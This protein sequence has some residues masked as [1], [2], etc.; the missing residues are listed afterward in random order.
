MDQDTVYRYRT[1]QPLSIT[2]SLQ[3]ADAVL[4]KRYS[5]LRREDGHDDFFPILMV[6]NKVEE[7]ELT[8]RG[9]TFLECPP[10]LSP[11]GYYG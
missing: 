1:V 10:E 6:Y 3:P 5:D 2:E 11:G 8:S 7:A 9:V 4:V